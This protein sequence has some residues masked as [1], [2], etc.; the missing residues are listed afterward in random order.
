M[1]RLFF[2]TFQKA[3]FEY[4]GLIYLLPTCSFNVICGIITRT[5][6]VVFIHLIKCSFTFMDYYKQFS[7]FLDFLKI[8]NGSIN[9]GI[10]QFISFPNIFFSNNI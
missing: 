8:F 3:K 1:S 9:Y 5:M 4:C 7:V 2:P 6:D 10:I